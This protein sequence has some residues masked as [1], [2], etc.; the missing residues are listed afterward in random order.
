MGVRLELQVE[1]LV[2]L[3]CTEVSSYLSKVIAVGEGGEEGCSGLRRGQQEVAA[4][5]N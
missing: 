4:S 2:S 1:G 5:Q 3:V